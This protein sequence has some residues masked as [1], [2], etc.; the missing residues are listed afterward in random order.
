M[1]L[2]CFSSTA[3]A[4]SS[5]NRECIA[6]IVTCKII[7]VEARLQANLYLFVTFFQCVRMS[8]LYFTVPYQCGIYYSVNCVLYML[9]N[10]L[11][12][13]KGLL[14]SSPPFF[15]LPPRAQ[16]IDSSNQ[17]DISCRIS[18]TFWLLISDIPAPLVSIMCILT[19]GDK[20]NFTLQPILKW[21]SPV[22]AQFLYLTSSST[23]VCF[24]G[25]MIKCG[26]DAIM[27]ILMVGVVFEIGLLDIV[28]YNPPFA[29]LLSGNK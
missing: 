5:W 6:R 16:Y 14:V 9:P 12:G 15:K 21:Q 23:D 27:K 3:A 20:A 10:L 13:M 8:E 1:A 24:S 7:G 28:E 17:F 4:L 25:T 22:V 18:L 11:F 29:S 2:W 19:Q 26:T